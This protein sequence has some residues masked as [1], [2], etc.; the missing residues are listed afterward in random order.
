MNAHPVK[1]GIRYLL[2]SIPR[3]IYNHDWREMMV[4]RKLLYLCLS[5][6]LAASSVVSAAEDEVSAAEY[7]AALQD[8]FANPGMLVIDQGETLFKTPRGPKNVSLEQC[9]FGLGP[10]KLEGAY[11]QFP[12]YFADTDKVQDLESRL[13]TCMVNLQ[14]FTEADVKKKVFADN[15]ANESNTDIEAITM[16]VAAQS[17]G[18]PINPPLTHAKEKEAKDM[19]EK[20]FF[21]RYG[22][23]DFSCATCHALDGKRIRLQELGNFADKPA[24]AQATMKTWPTYRVSHGVVR[25]LQSRMWDCHWQMRLPDLDYGSPVSVALIAYL[26]QQAKGANLDIPGMKR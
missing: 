21:T 15:R 16:Y 24:D 11:A 10:G 2:C 3:N 25:T 5:A 17:D 9:D 4:K 19:G 14:G 1:S 13:V 7:R 22:P 12:R 20:L 6:G 18:M 8:K 26:S 23:M